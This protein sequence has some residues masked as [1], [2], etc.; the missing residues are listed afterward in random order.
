MRGLEVGVGLV[1][2][3]PQPVVLQRGGLVAEGRGQH[4]VGVLAVAA[5]LVDP[6]LVD[7]VADVEHRVQVLLG[8]VPVGGEVAVL[9]RLAGDQPDPGA[10]QLAAV[11]GGGAGA[12]D[13]AAPLADGEPVPVL[14]AGVQAVGV[15]VHRP[16]ELGVRPGRAA[17]LGALEPLVPGDLP[18]DPHAARRRHSGAGL[19]RARREPGP[20]HH[21][22][23]QRVAGGDAQRER[24]LGEGARGEFVLL[25]VRAR[26]VDAEGER[27]GGRGDGEEPA[28]VEPGCGGAQL[29]VG[30]GAVGKAAHRSGTFR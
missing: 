8:E 17:T 11:V 26:Q 20:Q 25:G 14:A 12:S 2:R 21:G 7:V 9:V 3:V 19:Q 1:Q 22:L 23:R 16:V 6:V 13:G 15:H 10:V 18:A 4:A 27:G 28:A 5:G 24:V 29:L 30:G